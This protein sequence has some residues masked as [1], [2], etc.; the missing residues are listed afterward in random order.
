M[1]EQ[2][3]KKVQFSIYSECQ[4]DFLFSE[5]VGILA[6]VKRAFLHLAFRIFR[7]LRM[8]FHQELNSP[9]AFPEDRCHDA[10]F[11]A[12]L[13]AQVVLASLTQNEPCEEKGWTC[14]D[15]GPGCVS[16]QIFACFLHASSQACNGK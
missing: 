7:V 3:A 1:L 10:G 9:K 2:T 4:R 14:A 15:L 16:V 6:A 11:D 12:L 8:Y 5:D 13:T